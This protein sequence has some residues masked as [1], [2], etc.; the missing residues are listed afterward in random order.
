M[1]FLDD[2]PRLSE[3]AG[4]SLDGFLRPAVVGGGDDVPGLQLLVGGE[5]RSAAGDDVFEVVSP[6]DGS[7]VARAAKAGRD[8]MEAA[9]AAARAA[10]RDFTARPAAE[11]LEICARAAGILEAH[12]DDFVAAIV[13]DLGKT[14]EQARTDG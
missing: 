1:T 6:I 13:T 3:A 12:A 9:I 8:D 14:T 5:W 11:R 7:V 10:R 4:L 2:A